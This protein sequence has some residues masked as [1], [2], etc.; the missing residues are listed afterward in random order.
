MRVEF[1]DVT[2]T[3][4]FIYENDDIALDFYI[5]SREEIVIGRFLGF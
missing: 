4:C 5:I 3:A 1:L 2:L